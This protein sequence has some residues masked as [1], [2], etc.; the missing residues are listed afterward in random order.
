MG[1]GVRNLGRIGLNFAFLL[2]FAV[3]GSGQVSAGDTGSVEFRWSREGGTATMTGDYGT[4]T[5]GIGGF[6]DEIPNAVKL[7]RITYRSASTQCCVAID[8]RDSRL[9]GRNV[10]LTSLRPESAAITLAGFAS[11]FAPSEGLPQQC[12]TSP[13]EVALACDARYATPSFA[14]EVRQ[15]TVVGGSRTEVGDLT[16]FPVPFLIDGTLIPAPAS[17]VTVPLAARFTVADAG[18]GIDSG[19]IVTAAG[20]VGAQGYLPIV[21]KTAC[22]DLTGPPC[23]TGGQLGVAGFQVVTAAIPGPVGAAR[24]SIH[25]GNQTGA[26][27]DTAY[28][29]LIGSVQ[30]PTPVRI[31]TAT[32][33]ATLVPT[34]T[35]TPTSIRTST[36]TPTITST[37]KPT[38]TRVPSSTPSRTSTF[39]VT[40]T[41]TNT[42]TRT[43]TRT[44]TVTRTSTRTPSV[45]PTYTATHT[46]T[47][48]TRCSGVP[49]PHPVRA[50]GLYLNDPS[51]SG[52]P[53]DADGRKVKVS[54]N[55]ELALAEPLSSDPT[56]CG[57]ELR[58]IGT[59]RGDGS[60]IVDLPPGLWE[61]VGFPRA[62]RGYMYRDPLERYGIKRIRINP[63]EG[64]GIVYISGG[65]ADWPY[66]IT[67]AQ[68][69]VTFRLQI[70]N[71]V[72]CSEFKTL[73]VNKPG[74]VIAHK[75]ARPLTCSPTP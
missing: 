31:P 37:R 39:T 47:P 13:S 73:Q 1:A 29:F 5:Q 65:G 10:V 36:P 8:P 68:G 19:T 46:F 6:G 62:A 51:I 75:A 56:F 27:L 28:D 23:S 54:I 44:P 49:A 7:L 14:S 60:A 70:G 61:P 30:T 3:A 34:S 69:G 74:R 63:K 67:H 41:P 17:A 53:A 52:N 59:G 11:S 71:D 42:S 4:S 25:A 40:P 38:S 32:R 72:I 2:G 15:V 48:D 22:S 16:V 58:I 55:N 66:R 9:A 43:A 64:G 45:T 57:A 12:S 35:R 26:V 24:I 20:A 21:S 18:L 33:T 50:K